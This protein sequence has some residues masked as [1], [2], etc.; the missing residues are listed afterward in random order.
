MASSALAHD[1]T[2]AKRAQA[3]LTE[4]NET[5]ERRVEE[6]TAQLAST[7]ALVGSFFQHSSECH[8]ILVEDDG[9]FR[10]QEV[11][12][13]TLR[14]Y[15]MARN[16]VVGRRTEDVLGPEN[17]AEINRH[18]AQCLR[19]GGSSHYERMQ[20]SGVVE[21]VA[22]ATPAPRE[23]GAPRRLAGQRPRRHRTQNDSNDSCNNPR[24]WR[25]SDS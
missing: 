20:G 2:D 17:G 22:I 14:L 25:R 15:G 24:R 9:G 21:A 19:E 23:P 3:E 12:P 10:Y 5:L 1:I 4:I 6:R 11:N 8:A 16:E 7:E 18:L 13:A